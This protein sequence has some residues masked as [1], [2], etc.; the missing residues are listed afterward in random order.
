MP[1]VD[2]EM[3]ETVVDGVTKFTIA[4]PLT[5]DDGQPILDRFGKPR[6]TN[7]IADSAGELVRKIAGANLEVTRALDRA[8]KHIDTLKNKKPTPARVEPKM[9][10]KPMTD[11]ERMQIGLD[12]QDPRKAAEAAKRVVES[13]VPVTEITEE[14]K[15]QAQQQGIEARR[16]LAGEFFARHPE[17]NNAASGALLGKWLVENGYE[18][19]LDN[20][21]IA[22]AAISD[23][24]AQNPPKNAV[25]DNA[26]PGNELPN[27]G[28]SPSPTR[29]V[30][31]SGISNS[32]A[33]GTPRNELALTRAQALDMLHKEPRRYEAW[34]K[35]PAKNA[36][37]NKA[38][39]GR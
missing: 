36:I 2:L 28:A 14:V 30:P 10:G 16:R 29:R 32:Q 34:M 37:L 38:L 33:S 9:Q 3:R 24:L 8:N 20:L 12:L 25:P 13:V 26:A 5:G 17:Y 11:E 39:A 19:S 7:L 31:V 35:D 4:F 22:F 6:F 23:R 21:E 27:P 1:D 18:F 15:R